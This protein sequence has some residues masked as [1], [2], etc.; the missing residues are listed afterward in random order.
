[1]PLALA[2]AGWDTGGGAGG[3]QVG[4]QRGVAIL[5]RGAEPV[6]T[7]RGLP[8]DP[9]EMHS[10]YIETTVHGLVGGVPL[11]PAFLPMQD[12]AIAS[13]AELKH[14][15]DRDHSFRSIATTCSERSRPV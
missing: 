10:R 14:S 13:A 2:P 1:M 6:E 3:G 9:E 11:Y 12:G 5:A 7:R 4:V 8:G 15:D